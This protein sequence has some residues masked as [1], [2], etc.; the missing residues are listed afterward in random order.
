MNRRRPKPASEYSGGSVRRSCEHVFV[1]TTRTLIARLL[2]QG[3]T[4]SEIALALGLAPPTVDYH[5]AVLQQAN[6]S[7]GQAAAK[8]PHRWDVVRQVGTRRQV[9]ELL[10]NGCSRG[11]VARRLGVSKS[12]VSYHAR[13]LGMPVDARGARR[14]DWAAIQQFYDAGHSKRECEEH[15]GFSSYSWH[16]AVRRGALVPRPHAMPIEQLCAPSVPRGRENLKRRL[17]AAGLKANRCERCGLSHWRGAPLRMALHHVNGERHDN[18]LENL[19]LVCP[20]CH[21]QTE[22]FAGRNRPRLR[23]V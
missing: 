19:E 4:R 15:F 3:Q 2:G 23:A 16:A 6:R 18:R 13:R 20:N 11:E 1:S 22:T 9:E 17:I 12:T 7:A 8:A 10:N 14:Y 5:I 21:S